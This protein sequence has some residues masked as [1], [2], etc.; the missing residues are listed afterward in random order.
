MVYCDIFGFMVHYVD[1][2]NYV[3]YVEEDVNVLSIA[4]AF[5]NRPKLL[6]AKYDSS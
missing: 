3:D 6:I 5:C 1:A 4:S 2:I